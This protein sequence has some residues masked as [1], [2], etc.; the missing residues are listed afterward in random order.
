[1]VLHDHVAVDGKALVGLEEGERSQHNLH[2][3]G[4]GEE[5]EPVDDGAGEE[6]GAI[7]EEMVAGAGNECGGG[8]RKPS[9]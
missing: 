4:F 8:R 6:V 9:D 5:G 2:Q 1:M 3:F 7:G